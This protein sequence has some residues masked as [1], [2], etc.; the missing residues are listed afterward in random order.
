MCC[1]VLNESMPEEVNKA[2]GTQGDKR[3]R[4]FHLVLELKLDPVNEKMGEK[5]LLCPL[6]QST[7]VGPR[8]KWQC[9]R[10]K[11]PPQRKLAR[12]KS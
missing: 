6:S 11:R 3:E 1:G 2:C 4:V 10:W 8:R 7:H 5:R 9:P 12:P